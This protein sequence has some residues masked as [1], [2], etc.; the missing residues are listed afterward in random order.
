MHIIHML[1]KPTNFLSYLIISPIFEKKEFKN[2]SKSSYLSSLAS[3][4][5]KHRKKGRWGRLNLDSP[6]SFFRKN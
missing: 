1:K 5:E 6:G 4:S 3:D 2:F